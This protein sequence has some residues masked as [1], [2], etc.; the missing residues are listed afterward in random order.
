[1]LL[2][3]FIYFVNNIYRRVIILKN[4]LFLFWNIGKNACGKQNMY[5]NINKKLSIYYSYLFGNTS[6]FSRRNINYMRKFYYV[7]PIYYNILDNLTWN[8][9]CMLLDLTDKE[10]LYFYFK[11]SLFCRSSVSELKYLIDNDYYEIIKER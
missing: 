7:F 3:F 2:L 9:Y 8:H 11:I 5:E 6:N 10:S 4:R 1:M